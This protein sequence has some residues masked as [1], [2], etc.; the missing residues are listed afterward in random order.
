MWVTGVEVGVGRSVWDVKVDQYFC[1]GVRV[2]A[3][4]A[5]FSLGRAVISVAIV[6]NSVLV[7]EECEML[8]WNGVLKHFSRKEFASG[9]CSDVG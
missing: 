1:S 9:G 5:T 3:A 8:R 2:V 6:E 7:K 4:L